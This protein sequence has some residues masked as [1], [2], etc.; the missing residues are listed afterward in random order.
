MIIEKKTWPN[1]FNKILSG[2][3]TFDA[4][5]CDFEIKNGDILILREYDPIRKDY[6]GR[7]IKKR[8]T[9]VLKTK[10]QKYWSTKDIQKYGLQ[11]I[12]FK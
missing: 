6:T 9:F 3:K 7:S 11:I 5:L 4:R 1:S 10:N 12:S 8:V 2:K